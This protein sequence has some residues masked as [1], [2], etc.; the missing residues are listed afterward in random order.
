MDFGSLMMAQTFDGIC[1]F[2]NETAQAI[3]KQTRLTIPMTRRTYSF[4]Q[5]QTAACEQF[6]RC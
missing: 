5:L 1:V 4:L 2:M 6:T 3:L